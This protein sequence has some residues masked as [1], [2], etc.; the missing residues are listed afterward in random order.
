[1]SELASD[2][3]S[4]LSIN[5]SYLNGAYYDLNSTST[6]TS[7][8]FT[9]FVGD[10]WLTNGQYQPTLTIQPGE[11]ISMDILCASID[12]QVELEITSIMGSSAVDPLTAGVYANNNTSTSVNSTNM[13]TECDVWLLALDGV[14]LD[15]PRNSSNAKHL[16]LL[17][18]SRATIAVQCPTN[19][20]YYLQTLSS[21]STS[22][23]YYS[24]G[25][26]DTKSVQNLLVLNV[27]G[28]NIGYMTGGK[29]LTMHTLTANRPEYI[30]DLTS[31]TSDAG[32][33]SF[34][35]GMEQRG[36]DYS[37]VGD[38]DAHIHASGMTGV[39]TGDPQSGFWLGLGTDCYLP[40]F[41]NVDCRSLYGTQYKADS[42]PSVKAE[43][44]TYGHSALEITSNP[45]NVLTY[46]KDTTVDITVWSKYPKAFPLS[47]ASFRFQPI[48]YVAASAGPTSIGAMVAMHTSALLANNMTVFGLYSDLGDW[49]DT[50]PA[51]PG[52]STLRTQFHLP[53]SSASDLSSSSG[54]NTYITTESAL[55]IVHVNH[56]KYED[57]GMLAYFNIL[58]SNA[59]ADTSVGN[60]SSTDELPPE[61]TSASLQAIKT[62]YSTMTE[63]EVLQMQTNLNISAGV[64]ADKDA[65]DAVLL[66]PQLDPFYLDNNIAEYR[67]NPFGSTWA[68]REE[69][70]F[71][72]MTRTLTFNGCP[73]HFSV[74]QSSECAGTNATRA[75]L[76]PDVLMVPL[77]PAFATRARDATCTQDAI[78]IAL[79][80]VGIYGKSDGT[81]TC[82]D[83]V[84]GNASIAAGQYFTAC[85]LN[86]ENDGVYD[87]GNE[88][89]T[90]ADLMD[91]CSGFADASGYYKYQTAPACLLQQLNELKANAIDAVE[92]D[93]FNITNADGTILKKKL[94]SISAGATN[95]MPSAQ[96]GWA[97][98][99]FPIY[100][101]IGPRG[102]SMMPCGSSGAH[103]SIC[104]DT[105]NGYY[106]AIDEDN[107]MYRYYMSGEVGSAT[108]SNF[109]TH[110]ASA[111]SYAVGSGIFSNVSTCGRTDEP[112]CT[113]T[114]PN[115]GYAPYS[116]GCFMGCKYNETGCTLTR[117]RGV[118]PSYEPVKDLPLIPSTLFKTA[119]A[120]GD[121]STTTITTSTSSSSTSDNTSSINAVTATIRAEQSVLEE[122]YK[123]QQASMSS[124]DRPKSLIQFPFNHS[125]ALV[126]T[127]RE[128]IN[129]SAVYSESNS[130]HYE[131]FDYDDSN[132]I[133]TGLEADFDESTGLLY[134]ATGQGIYAVNEE[135]ST[136]TQLIEGY[137]HIT[138]AG[139][140]FGTSLSDIYSLMIKGQECDSV[141][142]HST[143]LLTCSLS[144]EGR[145]DASTY[146]ADDVELRLPGGRA[147]GVNYEPLTVF[148]S[149][150]GRPAISSVTF[151]ERAFRPLG[152]AYFT[153]AVPLT[154]PAASS[155]I[156]AS[157]TVTTTSTSCEP[158]VGYNTL[159]NQQNYTNCVIEACQGDRITASL[160]TAG[161]SCSGDTYLSLYSKL[162]DICDG[163]HDC[164]AKTYNG[165]DRLVSDDNHCGS[166][167]ELYYDVPSYNVT[168]DDTES[169]C[170]TFYLRQG[171]YNDKNCSGTTLVSITKTAWTTPIDLTFQDHE[172]GTR[173][174]LYW[175]DSA[176]GGYG[177]FRCWLHV[178]ADGATPSCSQTE[179]VA[180]SVQRARAL[181]VMAVSC[182]EY[183]T[184]NGEFVVD[185]NDGNVTID[186][187]CDLIVYADSHTSTV[188]RL[189]V[190]ALIPE[191]VYSADSSKTIYSSEDYSS[192]STYM[193]VPTAIITGLR[194][195]TGSN[196][197]EI[198]RTTS[199]YAST[200]ARFFMSLMEG[201]VL[202]MS[203]VSLLGPV[204]DFPIIINQNT[205]SYY[206]YKNVGITVVINAPTKA[207]LGGIE[208]LPVIPVHGNWTQHR[209]FV[210]DANQQRVFA[211]TEW[212]TGTP[213]ENMILEV[214]T[215]FDR[216]AILM[217]VDIAARAVN[218]SY[219]STQTT[220]YVAEYL[221]K[222]W[223][224]VVDRDETDKTIKWL[225]FRQQS[226]SLILDESDF[227]ASIR[228]REEVEAAKSTG[229]PIY[230]K[231]FFEA[232]I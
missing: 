138:I 87:C 14:Y 232:F 225:E 32:V 46:P 164:P 17:P 36:A 61:Y 18:G 228:I 94:L 156:E 226:P 142:L 26:A 124:F 191:S 97:L 197:D 202:K 200:Q 198:Y 81:Q 224:V 203:V 152:L 30:S 50:W 84:G 19:G 167:S 52:R 107:F 206:D 209:V 231:V 40:C 170:N 172:N 195:I 110:S 90:N 208:V 187:Q 115:V 215:A 106:G 5:V 74:C 165:T 82:V 213:Y 174:M 168:Q 54:R 43:T 171:C 221:G 23:I 131:V 60:Y 137:L 217:P 42:L 145:T 194:S 99:G 173:R 67:C 129:E 147:K 39:S 7:N 223:K 83:K 47:F 38:T 148:K 102:V 16:I 151:V 157:S 230:E 62:D 212:R 211:S 11:W 210:T 155:Q 72:T 169:A 207:R 45:S 12:R 132:L 216:A 91:M 229:Q 33:H 86:G 123:T 185:F 56:L 188:W 153:R 201:K 1:L 31:D 120:S 199:A 15:T 4:T 95:T 113:D 9:G 69:V 126:D 125:L 71:N 109:T 98:D 79:N 204:S 63:A 149:G 73:N 227:Q 85:A 134:F 6:T 78:G 76:H 48:N 101:P 146:V 111:I 57:H 135:T 96:I 220:F 140:N 10:A 144:G 192:H 53:P 182:L 34:S 193:G 80:G 133:I 59:T 136:R 13:D 127:P 49:R 24:V 22:S 186:D 3:G 51:L 119:A 25:T 139:L 218:S 77:Y 181:K 44:C 178:F 177:I 196:I 190:P 92:T 154:A 205:F 104:L 166:C 121:S 184:G 65:I 58:S 150:S 55:G 88:V 214:N 219:N 163:V 2:A 93:I 68:Y 162:W 189:L 161:S 29:N 21:S 66:A 179:L 112:C 37:S 114:I 105:C 222:I 116:I 35:I 27:T 176:G 130:V 160:C 41:Q 108:C 128:A 180:T 159:S 28:D 158:F 70:D 117:E 175:S 100:G 141:V 122:L 183:Y 75:L 103:A 8:N 20:T 143:S 118:T 64:A 89:P